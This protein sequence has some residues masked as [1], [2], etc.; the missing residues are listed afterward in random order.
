MRAFDPDLLPV[1]ALTLRVTVSALVIAAVVGIPAGVWLGLARFPGKRV[2]TALVYTGMALPPVVVGLLTYM[3]L[4]RS[5]PLAFLEWLFTPN[6]MILAQ[7][8][9]ALPLVA[10]LVMGAVASVPHDLVLQVRSLGATPW[11]VR[12]TILREVRVAVLFALLVAFGRI[13]SEVGA[14]YMVGGNIQGYTRVL[15]TAVMMETG[16]GDFGV[17]LA[18]GG[19]LMVLALTVN[20]AAMRLQGRLA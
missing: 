6:A 10:G 19:W 3:L 4:S 2:L 7:T 9:M 14:A 16:K 1:V 15:S 12:W 17:A 18:L 13:V 20:L 8:V 11:Q 5:G